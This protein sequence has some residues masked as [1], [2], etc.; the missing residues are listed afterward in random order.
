MISRRGVHHLCL[1]KS[2]LQILDTQF[3]MQK[4]CS[5]ITISVEHKF[6]NLILLIT[7]HYISAFIYSII[8]IIVV[9]FWKLFAS[10]RKVI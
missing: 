8:I 9:E 1:L 4:C 7:G 3:G 6:G 5:N 2:F 10:Q